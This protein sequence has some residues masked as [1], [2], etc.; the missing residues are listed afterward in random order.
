MVDAFTK[1]P[2]AGNPAAVCLLE[3]PVSDE[4]MQSVAA[5]MKHAETA[6]LTQAGD[7]YQL[8]WFTPT[9][10]VSLC[11]HAT[12]ASAHILWETARLD[13]AE[14][15][16]F[17]TK[18]GLLTASKIGELIQLNFPATPATSQPTPPGLEGALG[19]K[20]VWFGRNGLDVL[21]EL[22]DE[23]AVTFLKPDLDAVQALDVRGLIVTARAS[24]HDFVSRFFAPSSGVPE[25][26]VTGSSH[27]CL[28]PYW[29]ERLGKETMDGYQAS[30]R[31]G[32]V[33]VTVHG[34]R[35]LLGGHAVTIL[36]G[37][38]RC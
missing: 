38:L 32:L 24:S 10:E 14:E 27:C 21:A 34:D 37:T 13:L 33:R 17:D 3:S 15:A 29:S 22:Q 25:D 4:W 18:S 7:S 5:E 20:I 11:G 16:K 6:F 26:A 31:G 1:H 23:R 30:P 8:R 12:L 35:V 19:S 28:A 36:E 2:F 9:V